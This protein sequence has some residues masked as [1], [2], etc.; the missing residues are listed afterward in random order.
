MIKLIPLVTHPELCAQIVA[1][2]AFMKIMAKPEDRNF[3]LLQDISLDDVY[4][5]ADNYFIKFTSIEEVIDSEECD[6]TKK[7]TFFLKQ[8]SSVT[9]VTAI[10]QNI[11]YH[12]KAIDKD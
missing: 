2:F 7:I 3:L 12:L 1:Q 10:Q 6:L 8:W 9:D 5:K 4:N 11:H